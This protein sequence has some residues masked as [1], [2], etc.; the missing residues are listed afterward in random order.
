MQRIRYSL[1]LLLHLFWLFVD[2]AYIHAIQLVRFGFYTGLAGA[3]RR[4]LSSAPRSAI[5]PFTYFLV[6]VT[7]RPG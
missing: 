6:K 5:Q 2:V 1:L 3:V 7:V 4:S